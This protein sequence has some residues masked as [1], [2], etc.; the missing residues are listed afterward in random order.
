M[1]VPLGRIFG[2]EIRAHWSWI[3]ILAV[4]SVLFSLD[5]T[6]GGGSDWPPSLAWAASI[7]TAALVFVSVTA[8]ELAHVAVARRNGMEAPVV[9]VQLLGGTFV[10]Q[11]NP[12]TPGQEFRAA[13]AGPA[14][15]LVTAVL[16]AAAAALLTGGPVEINRAPQGLQAVQFVLVMVCVF[17]AFLAFI[18]L[19]PGYP[20]DGARIVHAV[21]WRQTGQEA[22]ATAVAI[23]VGRFVG[24]AFMAAGALIMAFL[25]LFAGLGLVVAGWLIV[26]SSRLLDRRTLLQGLVAGLHA[27]D[28]ADT[29]TARVPPQLTLDVFAAE[30][31]GERVGTAALVERGAELIGLLGTAQI[32]RIPRRSWTNTR[33]EQAMVPIANVPRIIA[34]TGLWTA[35][36]MLERSGLDALLLASTGTDQALVTRRSAA[37]LIQEK[38][39]EHQREMLVTGQKKRGRFR[40]L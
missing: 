6:T 4:I 18:N 9:V 3:P 23:R 31:L 12:R 32:R 19:I 29:E 11:L 30:Y 40:G 27:G 24:F 35:L 33:T 38:A 36:E 8:H 13:F 20:M 37:R 26:G 39:A 22:A 21:A 25:D 5:L 15:S 1:N 16:L 2:T 34:E 17:N 10:T 7:A 14:V 28:A